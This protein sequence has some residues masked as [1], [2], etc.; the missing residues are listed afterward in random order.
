LSGCVRV[1]SSAMKSTD[2]PWL[3]GGTA[4]L[5][6]VQCAPS[7]V[8]SSIAR[9][10]ST[11]SWTRPAAFLPARAPSRRGA[12][13]PRRVPRPRRRHRRRSFGRGVW[14]RRAV[15][16]C[17]R[18]YNRLC[19]DDCRFARHAVSL[20]VPRTASPRCDGRRT[21]RDA[22]GAP[23][24]ARGRERQEGRSTHTALRQKSASRQV[25]HSGWRP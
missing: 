20:T 10:G 7:S 4:A 2:A 14:V 25:G 16:A 24:T 8:G 22:C 9:N 1:R 21:A 19:A 18:Q 3:C 12:V 6:R 17:M 23:G 11:Y 15:R 5:T 13:T